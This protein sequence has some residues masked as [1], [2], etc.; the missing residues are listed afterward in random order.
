MPTKLA[1]KILIISAA[2][3][4]ILSPIYN[5]RS[6]R[7]PPPSGSVRIEYKTSNVVPHFG[8]GSKEREDEHLCRLEAHGIV[9]LLTV[10][11]SASFLI[12]I[13]G[14]EQVAAMRGLH[15]VYV[16]TNVA[17]IPLSSRKNAAQAIDKAVATMS[18]CAADSSDEGAEE[19]DAEDEGA[20]VEDEVQDE[21]GEVGKVAVEKKPTSSIGEDVIGRKGAYG[22]FAA[23]WF[24]KRGWT[25]DRRRSEGM[26]AEP[27]QDLESR[28]PENQ[29][30]P[31]NEGE[32]EAKLADEKTDEE[33]KRKPEESKEQ[34]T[35]EVVEA[36]K[37]T[38]T[39]SLTPKLLNTTKLLLAQSRSFYFSY[40]WDI[41]RSWGTEQTDGNSDLPLFKVVD[42]LYFWNKHLQKPF[43]DAGGHN[44]VLPLMQGF[45]AQT[46]FSATASTPATPQPETAGPVQASSGE[47][48]THSDAKA[49]DFAAK[50][51]PPN[52]QKTLAL[53]LISR[54]ST[55]RAGLRYLRRGVDDQGHTANSVETEQILSTPTWNHV[56]SYLQIRGSIPVF[57][58]QSPYSFRPRPVLLLS[59]ESNMAAMRLH[60]KLVRERYGDI[61]IVN[62]VEKN[63]P[64]SI[65]GDKYRDYVASINKSSDDSQK[66]GWT[67]FDFHKEC[68]GMR[69]ENVSRLFAEI[70]PALDGI[71]YTE[72]LA[73]E[74][75]RQRQT[76]VLRTNCMDCLDRTNVVQSGVARRALESQLASLG[77]ELKD[78][79]RTEWFNIIWADNGDAISKQYASTAAL[80]GDFTRTRKRNLQGAL[81]DFGLTMTR[82]FTNIISDYFTQAAID[83]L[84]G[85]VTAQVF[86]DFE[87][88]MISSDPA[89][90]M[91]RVRQNAIEIS[92][93]I[94]VA[95]E[96]E[97]LIGGWTFLSP[98]SPGTRRGRMVEKVLLLTEQAVYLC[99]FDWALEK[100][101][102]FERVP[103]EEVTGIQWGAYITSTLAASSIDEERNVGFLLRYRPTGNDLVRVNTRSLQTHPSKDKLQQRMESD[104]EGLAYS[105]EP[106]EPQARDGERF[107]AFKAISAAD[108]EQTEKEVVREVC[109]N[110]AVCCKVKVE[111]ADVVSVA[112]A[113]KGTGLVE[114][115][116]YTLKR[117][118]WA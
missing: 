26:S 83:F 73:S 9:G 93:K 61:H 75:I 60:F 57:F 27:V 49:A 110:L 35:E 41:T 82:Y 4:L 2:D 111:E 39:H 68:R 88:E 29:S 112:E 3:G 118:V 16:I 103:V 106:Q 105:N 80:K 65:V 38:V 52:D 78:N 100:V 22:R 104:D 51:T 69:F 50:A 43:I 44:F 94:V 67:W 48:A 54:R 101:S 30:A 28:M 79:D 17:L 98:L 21:I 91:R 96:S 37:E 77:I 108:S 20:N 74:G 55:R 15:P 109:E 45:V 115:W 7:F 97:A 113:K 107:W 92:G 76:G 47:D 56:F 19:T 95:D 114:R 70:G 23:R 14:R 12:A 53:T 59:E 11:P 102:A 116:G 85:N 25:V 33:T 81:T 31:A 62:L 71:S 13:T 89:V 117:L 46:T 5:S 8:S 6:T 86:S 87:A 10:S 66:I 36:V 34:K 1:R 42:P 64:E 24:S 18:Q 32:A 99:V 84:L 90:S 40:E 63:P 72:D 58:S